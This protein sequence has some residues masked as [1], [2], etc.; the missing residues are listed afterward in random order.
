MGVWELVA[1]AGCQL[2]GVVV[3]QERGKTCT[4]GLACLYKLGVAQIAVHRFW[5]VPQHPC[6]ALQGVP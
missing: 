6:Y 2:R 4:Q 1:R 3:D 5:Q